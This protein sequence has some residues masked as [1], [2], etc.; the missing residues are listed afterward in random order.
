MSP[1]FVRSGKGVALTQ[2]VT[3]PDLGPQAIDLIS[4]NESPEAVLNA[5]STEDAGIEWR[6]LGI[7]NLAGQGKTFSG[8]HALGIHATAQG[9]NCIALGN[10]LENMSVPQ[11]DD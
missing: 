1:A 7:L 6:Q 5:L 3:N 8:Q 11:G 10:L 4:D 9:K 2:N